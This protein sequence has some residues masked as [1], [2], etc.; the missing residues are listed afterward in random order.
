MIDE[1]KQQNMFFPHFASLQRPA[2]EAGHIRQAE[3][4]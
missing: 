3:Q 1:L 4:M 2:K